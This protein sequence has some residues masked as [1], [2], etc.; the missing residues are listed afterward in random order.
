MC[1]FSIFLH[2]FGIFFVAP[3]PWKISA[4]ALEYLF[5]NQIKCKFDYQKNGFKSVIM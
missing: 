5:N 2:I 1:Y 4:N 3:L